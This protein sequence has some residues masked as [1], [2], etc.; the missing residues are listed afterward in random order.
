MTGTYMPNNPL[1]PYVVLSP[2][3]IAVIESKLG[4]EVMNVSLCLDAKGCAEQL[5]GSTAFLRPPWY[6]E[7]SLFP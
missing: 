7:Q 1:L 2:F 4:H 5:C 3:F 6:N